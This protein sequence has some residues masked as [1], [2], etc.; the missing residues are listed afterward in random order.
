MTDDCELCGGSGQV[1]ITPI[2]E[3]DA[4]PDYFGCP[5]CMEAEHEDKVAGLQDE[6]ERLRKEL[7]SK[8]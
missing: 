7:A 2:G 3:P 8:L 5:M 6:I 1:N 4:K